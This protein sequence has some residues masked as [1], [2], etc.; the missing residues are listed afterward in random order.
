MVTQAVIL[1]IIKR[2]EVRDM[3]KNKSHKRRK[4]RGSGIYIL[5]IVLLL[6]FIAGVI[7]YSRLGFSKEKANLNDY[8]S[9]SYDDQAGVVID[10]A[11]MGAKGI[12]KD[13]VPY[14]EYETVSDYI[15]SRFYI[16]TNEKALLYA[17]PD[18]VI[19]IEEGAK[20]YN[21]GTEDVSV[22]YPIWMINAEKPYIALDFLEQY[23]PVKTS[24]AEN[25]N[26]ILMV[27]DFGEVQS[28]SVKK[29]T[30]IR[31]LAGV[32]SPILKELKKG[33]HLTWIDTVDDWYHVRTD[34][35]F[36]GYVPQK[37]LS[38]LKSEKISCEFVEP[39]V[40]HLLEQDKICLAFDNVT[41]STANDMLE[42]RLAN[43]KG[44]NVLAPT[45]FV[46]KD[47]AG[48]IESIASADYVQ[49]A[50]D[51]GMRVWATVRDF[52]SENGINSNDET[53]QLLSRTSVREKLIAGLIEQAKAAGIDGINVD[54]E[55]VSATCGTSYIQFI[56]E[57]SIKCRAEKLILS[58]DNYVPKAY[59]GHYGRKEQGIF[60]DYIVI[61]GYDEHTYGDDEAGSVAS[62]DFVEE[63]IE[64]TIAAVE[65]ERVINALPFYTRI[66]EE[67]SEG[68][69]FKAYDMAGAA[70]AVE[71]AGAEAVW[72]SATH[73]DYAE[74]TDG[75]TTYKVWLE[76]AASVKDKLAL[77]SDFELAGVGGWRLGQETADIW[78][79]IQEYLAK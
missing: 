25:P 18:S 54:F 48:T 31:K 53:Y 27:T 40:T 16:D 77:M 71:K 66:W 17:L 7:I 9:L 5:I 38:E 43:T 35:G 64:K 39:Q 63:G 24:F 22:D 41:N 46:V 44:I 69:T 26:H 32:K 28:T 12:V 30:Q 79:L 68:L 6:I 52:D 70:A 37:H 2:L 76:N 29:D 59:N 67:S 15:S 13:G 56:R 47:T 23:S 75:S 33:E 45:W 42:E 78:P 57:L 19:R 34:D 74:W 21:N 4:R 8:F 55:K 1:G 49:K 62:Y 72:D 65:P 11:V 50:H 3:A 73:Q 61:M 36:I 10:N 58:V 60:A 51:K 14:V 20:E